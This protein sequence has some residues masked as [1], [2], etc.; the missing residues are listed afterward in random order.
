MSFEMQKF[1]FVG[2]GGSGGVTLRMLRALLASRLIEAGYD[3]GVPAA[4]QFVHIDVPMTQD[5]R[6]ETVPLLDQNSYVGLAPRGLR[7]TALDQ[8]LCDQ[9]ESSARHA[10]PWRPSP[11]SIDIDPTLGAGKLRA[12]GRVIMGARMGSATERLRPAL[13]ALRSE[14]TTEEF[15]RVCQM[16]TGDPTISDQ[17]AQVVVVSSLAG[18]SGAGFVGDVCDLIKQLDRSVQDRLTGIFYTPQVFQDL[19]EMARE[20]MYSNALASLSELLN[21]GWGSQQP[22]EDEFAFIQAAGGFSN[23]PALRRGPRYLYMI[24]NGN[25]DLTLNS[26]DDVFQTV[27][28]AM[29][30][31]AT[32]PVLQD[33]FR[34]YQ[35]ANWNQA[36]VRYDASGL[37]TDTQESPLSSFGCA[38]VS[39]GLDRLR[40][41]FAERLARSAIDHLLSGRATA[42]EGEEAVDL[43]LA[44][45]AS[46]LIA[47]GLDEDGPSKNEIIDAIRGG[48][49]KRQVREDMNHG[50]RDD[51]LKRVLDRWPADYLDPEAAGLRIAER[52]G[53]VLPSI[54]LEHKQRYVDGANQWCA[55]LQQIVA[56]QAAEVIARSGVRVALLAV[57]DAAELLGTEVVAKLKTS[58]G[59]SARKAKQMRSRVLACM[60]GGSDRIR[61]GDPRIR[62]AVDL[63]VDAIAANTETVVYS[64]AASVIEDLV[65]RML[66]PL[67][68]ALRQT[69]EE[70]QY[71]LEG[72][73]LAPSRAALWPTPSSVPVH[74]KPAQNELLLE[75]VDNYPTLF[76]DL[77]SKQ[78]DVATLSAVDDARREVI[79]GR[80]GSS[81]IAQPQAVISIL[82]KWTPRDSRLRWQHEAAEARFGVY[83]G[84]DALLNRARNWTRQLGTPVCDYLRQSLADYL[85]DAAG[86]RAQNER[87]QRF[88][89]EL[90]RAVRMSKPLVQLDRAKELEIHRA[91]VSYTAEMSKFPFPPGHPARLAVRSVLPDVDDD[92]YDDTPRER[93]DIFTF[94]SAPVQPVVMSS[95]VDPI[96]QRWESAKAKGAVADF[97]RARRAKP[98]PYFVPCAP[99]VRHAMVRGWFV[100]RLLGQIRCKDNRYNEQT[101]EIW[102][103]KGWVAF[104]RPLLGARI[105][106]KDEWLPAV[107]ES[108]ALTLIGE[109]AA[110][111]HR[112]TQL[113]KS[114][115]DGDGGDLAT[116]ISTGT[117]PGDRPTP[118]HRL[119]GSADDTSEKR[120]EVILGQLEGLGRRNAEYDIWPLGP[121]Q[122][123]RVWEMHSDTR[124]ALERLREAAKT[125]ASSGPDDDDEL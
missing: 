3:G 89:G 84:L 44:M 43:R 27:A 83:L 123:T 66:K 12:V 51:L 114:I 93:I 95:L 109:S 100:A 1:L 52:A 63:A 103:T 11:E 17:P 32:D 23:A 81:E 125:A 77:V 86:A 88:A 55:G 73:E 8:A 15:H 35:G 122:S 34:G 98:L 24:G 111:Y 26:Q 82:A 104:P 75:P 107:L 97:W 40:R 30:A 5:R 38:S 112:L 25:D 108:L 110:P 39:I 74:Y 120:S 36:A 4:W 113:G 22:T 16:L 80:A 105:K 48:L 45:R 115:D 121:E 57:Q 87:T 92:D 85:G 102:T 10:W 37:Q 9:S 79:L 90:S 13:A 14:A 69:V 53:E 70:L 106:S 68:V 21:G 72:S 50:L 7:Y 47:T 124:Q 67:A 49:S 59:E 62:Q 101:T 2:L 41:Y 116:W 71:Q 58:E 119:A 60:Q 78:M 117:V 18:G 64:L 54:V 28:R 31:W 56:D 19:D 20:G 33:R 94:Q 29:T 65:K 76:N 99:Q 42:A 118:D 96:R 6:P 91:A 46:F 61:S